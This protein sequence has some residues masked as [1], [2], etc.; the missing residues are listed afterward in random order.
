MEI[1]I[2]AILEYRKLRTE[3]ERIVNLWAKVENKVGLDN[4]N[5]LSISDINYADADIVVTVVETDNEDGYFTYRVPK[6]IL[7]DDDLIKKWIKD[8][9]Y[10]KIIGNN[11]FNLELIDD[12]EIEINRLKKEIEEL[13][14][15]YIDINN[16]NWDEIL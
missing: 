14:E 3:L 15:S 16:V 2:K 9:V 6:D 13:K 12:K 10:K 8:L 1:Y 11:N 7:F 5:E 4:W